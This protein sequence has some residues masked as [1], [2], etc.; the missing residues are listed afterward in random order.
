MKHKKTISL[1]VILLAI[2]TSCEELPDPAG[3]RGVAVVPAITDINPGIFDSKDLGNTYVEFSVT[4]PEGSRP[5]KI[6][7]L[8]SYQDN[9]ERVALAEITSFPSTVRVTAKD[10]A[11]KTGVLLSDI[12]NGDVF[13]IELLTTANNTSTYSTAVLFVPVAC[14][15][16]VDLATGSYHSVTDWPYENDV[17]IAADP[18]DPYKIL[19]TDMGALDGAVE[20]NGPFVL[21]IN[22]ATY[23][24]TC[25]TKAVTSDYY[26]YGAITYSGDG[27]FSSCDGSYVLYI[28]ISVGAYGS[29][30]VYKFELTR[31]P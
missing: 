12:I 21:H 10:I 2:I 26:G 25:E 17:T 24:I 1:V 11:Q 5:D 15:Y 16:D 4:V 28:D 7:V 20:D 31:N 23:E 14:A 13:A 19:I 3:L 22:P 8:G 30:G 27:V 6:V 18:N 9:Y 29:Q